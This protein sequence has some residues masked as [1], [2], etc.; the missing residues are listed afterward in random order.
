MGK[1]FKVIIENKKSLHFEDF[2]LI[3]DVFIVQKGVFSTFSISEK[4]SFVSSCCTG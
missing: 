4:S 3:F 2:T 1:K